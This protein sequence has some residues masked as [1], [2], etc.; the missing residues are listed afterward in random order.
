MSTTQGQSESGGQ[1]RAPG[2]FPPNAP[3]GPGWTPPPEQ[4]PRRGGGLLAGLGIA[5]ALLL[6]AA[7]LVVGVVALVRQ[8]ATSASS[9]S[10][11]TSA[12]SQAGDTT[13]ADRALCTAIA[14]IMGDSD[15][16]SNAYTNLGAAGTP[17]RDAATP[18]FVTD[19]KDWTHRAQ[20]AL[21]AHSDVQPF[22]RHSLQRYIDDRQILVAG[23]RTGPLPPY[24]DAI[25]TDSMA[26]YNGPITACGDLGIKW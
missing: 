6:S 17:D 2:G 5:L 10:S 3:A 23:L 15:R 7:A 22:L 16:V 14:P 18:Q 25:W 8:P 9:A 24:Q 1:P 20:E 12:P 11:T 13:A 26:A 4:R 21:D 19:T